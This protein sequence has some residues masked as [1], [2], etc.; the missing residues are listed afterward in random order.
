MDYSSLLF[1]VLRSNLINTLRAKRDI[2]PLEKDILD[3]CDELLKAPFD[4]VSAKQQIASN[5]INHPKI[6]A[7]VTAMPT[8]VLKASEQITE[9]DLR[10][11]LTMQ[12]YGLI[13][14]EGEANQN[15]Q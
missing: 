15:G 8:T 11:L 5:D 14:K 3:T 4:M 13:A 6:A 10:Y 7:A 12:L 9:R 1:D 2:T